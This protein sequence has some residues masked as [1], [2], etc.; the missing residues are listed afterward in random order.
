VKR[1]L[2]ETDGLYR[3]LQLYVTSCLAAE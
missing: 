3:P 2:F 1:L